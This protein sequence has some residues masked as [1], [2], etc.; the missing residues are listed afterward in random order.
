M[1][2][3]K[4]IAKGR[5]VSEDLTRFAPVPLPISTRDFN[6]RRR[7]PTQ[8]RSLKTRRAILEAALRVADE[9]GIERL[10]MQ[11]IA[12][13]AK[14]AAGT[15]Y[16]FY[17]DRDAICSDIY[18]EWAEAYWAALMEATSRNLT[19][20]NWEGEL[21]ALVLKMG[22]FW[23]DHT[24]EYSLLRYVESTKSG[25]AAMRRMVDANIDRYVAWFGPLLRES[26][27]APAES[28]RICMAMVRAIRGHWAYGFASVSESKELIRSASEAVIAIAKQS[29][30]DAP[31]G[32]RAARPSSTTTSR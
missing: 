21:R 2:A 10:T 22:R 8:K 30:L 3:T 18:L 1:A 14:I 32:S 28:R 6:T 24:A 4:R 20:E 16:Q 7:V 17:D 12:A 5:I 11:S 29:F 27:Y 31:R 19:K 13:K 26:G 25:G 23:F 9:Q 15:A